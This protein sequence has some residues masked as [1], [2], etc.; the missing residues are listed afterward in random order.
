MLKLRH[1]EGWP[2]SVVLAATRALLACAVQ[3]FGA[4]LFPHSVFAI[5]AQRI[6]HLDFDDAVTTAT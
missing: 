5:H 1:I 6:G 3:Q 2:T 4:D